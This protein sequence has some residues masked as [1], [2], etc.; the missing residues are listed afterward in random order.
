MSDNPDHESSPC[1]L[2]TAS[3]ESGGSFDDEPLNPTLRAPGYLAQQLSEVLRPLQNAETAPLTLDDPVSN[4][5]AQPVNVAD[6]ANALAQPHPA[7]PP[8]ARLAAIPASEVL[9]A[10]DPTAEVP[11]TPG[12]Q[13]YSISCLRQI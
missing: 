9:E 6:A 1:N 8:F 3:G 11:S 2:V 5:S 12:N 10:V 4:H 7:P 13:P